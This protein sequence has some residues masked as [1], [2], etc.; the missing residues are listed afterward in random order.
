MYLLI[1]RR[2][3]CLDEGTFALGEP[4]P[5]EPDKREVLTV[6]I[7]TP[8]NLETTAFWSDL[9]G[10]GSGSDVCVELLAEAAVRATRHSKRT[11][12]VGVES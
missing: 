3:I 12:D 1:W 9:G 2:A 7:L 11:R 10:A 6:L 5:H 4:L 8:G